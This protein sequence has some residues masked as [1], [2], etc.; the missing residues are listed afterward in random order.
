[1]ICSFPRSEIFELSRQ[2]YLPWHVPWISTV[3]VR[4]FVDLGTNPQDL[5]LPGSDG[6]F[7]QFLDIAVHNHG[8]YKK[9]KQIEYMGLVQRYMGDKSMRGI[10]SEWVTR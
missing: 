1:M 7:Y 3:V 4:F 5:G 2:M 9:E 6:R 10:S 8:V